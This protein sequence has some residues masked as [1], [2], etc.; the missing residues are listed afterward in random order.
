MGNLLLWRSFLT[1]TTAVVTACCFLPER[2]GKGGQS[3]RAASAAHSLVQP[4]GMEGLGGSVDQPAA[5]AVPDSAA[6]DLGTLPRLVRTTPHS[7]FFGV[8][9]RTAVVFSASRNARHTQNAHVAV[10]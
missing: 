1:V 7:I 3:G 5:S 4:A 8:V 10:S 6:A 2:R 9:S